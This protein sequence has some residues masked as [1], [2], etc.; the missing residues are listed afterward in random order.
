MKVLSHNG[1]LVAV[2]TR[3]EHCPPHVHA[4]TR[5]W[6]ERFE[7]SFCDNS[8]RQ[9]D[10]DR[11]RRTPGATVLEELRQV[12]KLPANLRKARELWWNI[13]GTLCL[14]NQQWDPI[15]EEVVPPKKRGAKALAIV[16]ARFDPEAYKTLLQLAGETD[17]LEIE[18]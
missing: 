8:V 6:S 1:I 14:E 5:E 2:F 13:H 11:T 10:P 15:E 17:V 7:F 4:G 12:I 18:L 16:S 3:D 9:L